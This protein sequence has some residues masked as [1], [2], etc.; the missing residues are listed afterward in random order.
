[1]GET[2]KFLPNAATVGVQRLGT[3][4]A[5][6]GFF[7]VG[8]R[9]TECEPSKP[10]DLAIEPGTRRDRRGP[11]NDFVSAGR[12]K[13]PRAWQRDPDPSIAAPATDLRVAH[14]GDGGFDQERR[15][16]ASVDRE[17]HIGDRSI[18]GDSRSGPVRVAEVAEP[19]PRGDPEADESDSHLKFCDVEVDFGWVIESAGESFSLTASVG[20]PG[21]DVHDSTVGPGAKRRLAR[22]GRRRSRIA[23]RIGDAVSDARF[24][25]DERAHGSGRVGGRELAPKPADIDVQVVSFVGIVGAPDGSQQ[26]TLRE[27]STWLNSP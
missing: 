27:E 23:Q 8:E 25:G 21:A 14:S 9:T 4:Q 3:A 22:N 12:P 6:S 1:M 16:P 11:R 17:D 15:S 26:T 19:N 13:V 7:V 24:R 5:L 2:K 18:R 10:C 20:V